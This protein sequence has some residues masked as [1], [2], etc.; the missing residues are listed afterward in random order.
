MAWAPVSSQS[1]IDNLTKVN[2]RGNRIWINLHIIFKNGDINKP[3]YS[4]WD[5]QLK[6]GT[7]GGLDPLITVFGTPPS[8]GASECAFSSDI[9]KW[10]QFA[11]AIAIQHTDQLYPEPMVRI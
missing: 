9:N 5:G 7:S 2:L 4:L 1:G 6:R 3:D 8:L 10:V 11:V